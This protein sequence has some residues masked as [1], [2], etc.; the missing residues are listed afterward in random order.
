MNDFLDKMKEYLDKGV[1]VSKEAVKTAGAKVQ[2][3][4]DKSMTLIEVRQLEN[5]IQQ[6][7]QEL[8]LRVYELFE[9]D[10]DRPVTSDDDIIRKCLGDIASLHKEIDKRNA[11]L[12]KDKQ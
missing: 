1:E 4:G 2:D 12:G 11:Q 8:G 6:N 10:M 7:L 3:F 9:E 5:K